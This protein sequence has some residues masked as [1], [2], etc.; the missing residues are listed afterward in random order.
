MRRP[1]IYQFYEPGSIPGVPG[2][3][4]A[5]SRVTVDPETWA[6]L[7]VTPGFIG[8]YAPVEQPPPSLRGQ[9][10]SPA[11]PPGPEPSMADPSET[12]PPPSLV[13]SDVQSVKRIPRSNGQ[14]E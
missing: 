14:E 11:P 5:G 2:S 12:P 13:S 10:S 6:V 7:E 8:E 9:E 4:P 1:L 3:F